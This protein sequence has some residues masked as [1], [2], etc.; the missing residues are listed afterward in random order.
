MGLVR[1]FPADM[2]G[3]VIPYPLAPALQFAQLSRYPASAVGIL[4]LLGFLPLLA[5]EL[6]IQPGLPATTNCL[7]GW[8]GRSRPRVRLTCG[9]KTLM[10]TLHFLALSTASL[11]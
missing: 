7:E 3:V 10:G 6:R 5:L 11:A 4:L 2:M 9:L 8:V 1:Q